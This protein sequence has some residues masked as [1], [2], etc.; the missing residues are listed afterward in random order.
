MEML[1]NINKDDWKRP[2]YYAVTIGEP[3]LKLMDQSAYEGIICRIT[4]PGVIDSTGVNVDAMFENMV[5]RY[6]WGGIEN[7]NVYLDENNLRLCRSFRLMFSYLIRALLEKGDD[8]RA[9]IALDRS[10]EVLPGNTVPRG[11]ES[12]E[13]AENY[14]RLGHPEKAQKII[15]EILYRAEGNLQWYAG[16]KQSDMISCSTNI[17][18][19][20]N[21]QIQILDI[22]QH[23]DIEKYK[24]FLDKILAS[25]EVFLVNRVSFSDRNHPLDALMRITMRRYMLNED[26]VARQED[27]QLMERTAGLMQKYSPALLQKYYQQNN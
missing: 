15:E 22:Y 21:I 6:K 19:M 5:N 3:P 24:P 18:D 1:Y 16:M 2:I 20:L 8:E 4:P 12:V 17:R 14:Y 13:Y 10:V 25:T 7:P 9:L 26:T 11:A 23:Y 27:G